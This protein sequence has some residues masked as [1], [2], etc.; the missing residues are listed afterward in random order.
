MAS[1]TSSDESMLLLRASS[2]I[3][4][5]NSSVISV[6][7]GRLRVISRGIFRNERPDNPTYRRWILRGATPARAS[8]LDMIDAIVDAVSSTL[9]IMP[10]YTHSTMGSCSTAITSSL[11]CALA[12]PTAPIILE[13][14]IS[15]AAIYFSWLISCSV[16]QRGMCMLCSKRISG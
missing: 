7:S 12:R 11:P 6:S 16:V 9:W 5:S 4:A 8:S 13:L 2:R 15:M 14:H 1:I 10:W 3:L